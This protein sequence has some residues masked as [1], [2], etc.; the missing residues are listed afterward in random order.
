MRRLAAPATL[1]AI[2]MLSLLAPIDRVVGVIGALIAVCLALVLYDREVG[3]YVWL[4]KKPAAF[5][6][7]LCAALLLVPPGYGRF[8]GVSLLL[9]LRAAAWFLMVTFGLGS[10]FLVGYGDL[11]SSLVLYFSAG[12]TVSILIA[13]CSVAAGHPDVIPYVILAVA[14][15]GLLRPGRRAV[16]RPG[17]A[18]A[19]IL[20]CSLLLLL[21]HLRLVEANP[22]VI[23][24]DIWY[25]YG[26]ARILMAH[27]F[28]EAQGWYVGYYPHPFSLFVL[29][30]HVCTGLPILETM[31]LVTSLVFI[32][33]LSCYALYSALAESLTLESGR[34][35]SAVAG[36]LF[37]SAGGL[38]ALYFMVTRGGFKG[39]CYSH[40]RTGDIIFSIIGNLHVFVAYSLCVILSMEAL[41][42]LTD[43]RA[44][45]P[46]GELLA[47][48]IA[49]TTFLMHV[50][51]PIMLILPVYILYR[52]F[53]GPMSPRVSV[54][55]ILA[56]IL[57][58]FMLEPLDGFYELR[59]AYA[60]FIGQARSRTV[61][62]YGWKPLIP[63]AA[64]GATILY[65][66]WRVDP[67]RIWH[68]VQRHGWTVQVVGLVV[69][70][71]LCLAGSTVVAV[72]AGEQVYERLMLPALK[73]MPILILFLAAMHVEI[74]NYR[75]VLFLSAWATAYL[76]ASPLL[77]ASRMQLY[78]WPALC[79]LAA[80]A[81]VRGGPSAILVAGL[82]CLCIVAFYD[83]YVQLSFLPRQSI[84]P[85]Y[86]EAVDLL[87]KEAS[88][89]GRV[90]CFDE[91]NTWI[92]G[93]FAA[94]R[95]TPGIHPL[96]AEVYGYY[97]PAEDP[98]IWFGK[99]ALDSGSMEAV[100]TAASG[101]SHA[102][103]R[104]E[105]AEKYPWVAEALGRIGS[106][107]VNGSLIV[108]RLNPV[109]QNISMYGL[110]ARSITISNGSTSITLRPSTM[111]VTGAS[112]GHGEF[113]LTVES[114]PIMLTATISQKVA[115][116]TIRRNIT[117]DYVNHGDGDEN[118]LIIV[119]G[120]EDKSMEVLV[121]LKPPG[122]NLSIRVDPE[123]GALGG[124][125][126]SFKPSRD[127]RLLLQVWDGA[128]LL[129]QANL[130][131]IVRPLIPGM[132]YSG[133]VMVA[134]YAMGVVDAGTPIHV[135]IHVGGPTTLK[136][137]GVHVEVL[138]AGS[139][140]LMVNCTVLPSYV[141]EAWRQA[142]RVGLS[143]GFFYRIVCGEASNGVYVNIPLI[144]VATGVALAGM[145][146]VRVLSAKH[147]RS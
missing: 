81:A 48:I 127:E 64:M 44:P 144:S 12:C 117:I 133:E 33:P 86:A 141:S 115:R 66:L 82:S 30:Y 135:G 113:N 20:A 91:Y 90:L 61:F 19:S 124:S 116:G 57:V 147:R 53:S 23:R 96:P 36:L 84:D 97:W 142:R 59:Y 4:G 10:I 122:G 3:G 126:L 51:E 16:R 123:A 47:G 110:Y 41:A 114:G 146:S 107:A 70:S 76:A 14:G 29:A 69:V 78:A 42:L 22:G 6:W 34:K 138:W 67:G 72:W 120:L 85:S 28:K 32:A 88:H 137:S 143:T 37:S 49:G 73:M 100:Y 106:V 119:G 63:L 136:L 11:P 79:M 103:L 55:H 15:A 26:E 50:M 139:N 118:M 35:E 131:G 101:C 111:Q 77:W 92:V 27:G 71:G 52:V 132:H 134:E 83:S 39:L 125:M 54:K 38:G 7:I 104:R 60:R 13:A 17:M 87:Y 80:R 31:Q 1:A 21:L 94:A 18:D 8:T 105:Q 98:P 56:G 68:R 99:V 129:Y 58:P 2:S 112:G 102:V 74:S 62:V 121:P 40:A 140:G 89:G 24:G 108:Y 145:H 75:L 130:S 93:F 45:R 46:A 43:P 9:V 5:L 65:L 25:R 95:T 128:A 109:Q